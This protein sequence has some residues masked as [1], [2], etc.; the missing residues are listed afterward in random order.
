MWFPDGSLLL[1]YPW[2]RRS[3]GHCLSPK[4]ETPSSRPRTPRHR[5]AAPPMHP[6]ND[7]AASYGHIDS[8]SNSTETGQTAFPARSAYCPIW[9][10]E[11]T[12]D[13]HLDD[14]SRPRF[15]YPRNASSADVNSASRSRLL[16]CA[17]ASSTSRL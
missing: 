10:G 9:I 2:S 15:S 3:S 5:A 4:D 6:P 14:T 12:T 16:R 11:S 7:L 17:A 13:T 8:P 1:E